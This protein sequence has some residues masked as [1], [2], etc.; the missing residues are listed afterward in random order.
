MTRRVRRRHG[1][2]GGSGAVMTVTGLAFEA[3]IA[4]T[5]AIVG[6]HLCCGTRL[7]TETARGSRGIISFG[8][9]GG[10]AGDL[11]P[12]Q[13]IVAASVISSAG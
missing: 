7:R 5:A 3:R 13:C 4:D 9:A 2:T 12:G 10:L 11:V 1:G 8:I 6:Q